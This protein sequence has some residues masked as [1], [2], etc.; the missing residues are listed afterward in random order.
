MLTIIYTGWNISWLV[1]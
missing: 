1:S